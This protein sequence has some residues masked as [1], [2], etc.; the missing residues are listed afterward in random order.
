MAA[1]FGSFGGQRNV[2]FPMRQNPP[3]ER[4]VTDPFADFGGSANWESDWQN[5]FNAEELRRRAPTPG[6]AGTTVARP[7]TFDNAGYLGANSDVAAATLPQSFNNNS[8]STA[9]DPQ[10]YVDNNPDVKDAIV[11]G[12]FLSAQDHF[13]RYGVN[14]NRPTAA[15]QFASGAQHFGLHGAGENRSGANFDDA[16]YLNLN[17]DVA[18][19]VGRGEFASG[20][21]HFGRHGYN[22]N[23]NVAQTFDVVGASPGIPGYTPDFTALN[24]EKDRLQPMA[25]NQIRQQQ[26]YN[27]MDGFGQQNAVMGDDYTAAGFG[28]VSGETNP[29]APAMGQAAFDLSGGN[30]GISTDW[31]S[32]VYDPQKGQ[33]AGVYRPQQ[34]NAMGGWG[35]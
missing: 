33:A 2:S 15:A 5:R 35:L 6:S 19:A 21:D 30:D 12:D 20:A 34:N 9:F 31:L 11:R 7:Q 28:Q 17:P 18:A 24:A 32:G 26:A 1:G 25:Q 4:V 8:Q 3:Q 23:R 13:T 22:E 14:E 27:M 16:A 10:F 29:F